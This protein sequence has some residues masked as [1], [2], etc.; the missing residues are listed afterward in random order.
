V[1]ATWA[2]STSATRSS[3]SRKVGRA[4]PMPTESVTEP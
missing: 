2:C 3:C 1:A 4:P